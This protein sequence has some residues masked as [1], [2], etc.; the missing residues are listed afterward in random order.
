MPQSLVQF[1]FFTQ[2][3]TVNVEQ[4][5]MEYSHILPKVEPSFVLS[6]QQIQKDFHMD[7]FQLK[8]VHALDVYYIWKG[9]MMNSG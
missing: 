4:P 5:T 6:W 8:T 3:I 1:S 9:A 7:M 2:G